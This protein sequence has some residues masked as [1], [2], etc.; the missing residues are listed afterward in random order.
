MVVFE[1]SIPTRFKE[2][3]WLKPSKRNDESFGRITF[4]P[5]SSSI[6]IEVICL[7][8]SFQGLWLLVSKPMPEW[9]VSTLSASISQRQDPHIPEANVLLAITSIAFCSICSRITVS[10]LF[11]S[12]I[13]W[14]EVVCWASSMFSIPSVSLLGISWI[15]GF[16]A[17][18]SISAEQVL[19]VPSI[20]SLSS[21]SIDMWSSA[22]VEGS[23]N[24][25]VK[26]LFSD[27][28]AVELDSLAN[29]SNC[30]SW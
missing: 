7:A 22:P 21:T 17:S 9:M 13:S 1:V 25:S 16:C 20:N 8:Y 28:S 19:S 3:K 29:G 4:W 5:F 10:A 2:V 24:T 23:G 27:S 15:G 26:T 11:V 12:S 14:G 18:S 6:T 30:N